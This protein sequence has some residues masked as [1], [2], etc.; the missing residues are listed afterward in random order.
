MA[1]KQCPICKLEQ[2]DKAATCQACGATFDDS[3]RGATPAATPD[4]ETDIEEVALAAGEE[5]V[6]EGEAAQREE[7]GSS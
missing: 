2:D 5:V 7:S 1:N 4:A 3:P 6:A